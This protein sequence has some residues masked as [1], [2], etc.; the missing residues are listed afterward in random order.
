MAQT[1]HHSTP[2]GIYKSIVP[3]TGAWGVTFWHGSGGSFFLFNIE[4]KKYSN[5]ISPAFGTILVL[6]AACFYSNL[7]LKKYSKID[8]SSFWFGW[9][10]VSIQNLI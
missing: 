5:L 4:L 1:H 9:Q 10:L 3:S 7:N 8:F 2:T 6:V